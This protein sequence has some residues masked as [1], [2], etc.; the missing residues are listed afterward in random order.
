LPVA[1]LDVL[2][3]ERCQLA[4][5]RPVLLRLHRLCAGNPFYALELA[6]ALPPGATLAPGEALALPGSLAGLLRERLTGLPDRCQPLVLAAA[7][8]AQPTVGLLD[9]FGEGF[10]EALAAGVLVRDG[11][12]LGFPHP[13][14]GSLAYADATPRS[15]D[16]STAASP[17]SSTTLRSGRCTWPCL[18]SSLTSMS[19]PCSR[20]LPGPPRPVARRRSPRTWPNRPAG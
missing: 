16:R 2:L 1:A 3:R 7:A 14:L 4:L 8:L 6:R 19:R 20:R 5:P 9:R 10:Q 12:R 11:D 13:L 17:P 15:A 18:P